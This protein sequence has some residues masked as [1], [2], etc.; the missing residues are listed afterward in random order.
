[1]A[2]LTNVFSLTYLHNKNTCLIEQPHREGD[3][4]KGEGV[5]CR[6]DD[7]G[8][9]EDG[10][11]DMAA[12]AAHYVSAEYAEFGEQPADYRNL[13]DYAHCEREHHQC[14]DVGFDGDGVLHHLAHLI[15]SEEAERERKDEEVGQQHSE[16]E[17]DITAEHDTDGTAPLILIKRRR[18]EMKEQIKQVRRSEDYSSTESHLDMDDELLSQ[19]CVDKADVQFFSCPIAHSTAIADEREEPCAKVV[20]Q[21]VG[22]EVCTLRSKDYSE[23]DVFKEKGDTTANDNSGNHFDKTAA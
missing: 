16:H 6:C 19:T 15:H 12:I 11:K 3:N 8:D 23:Q 5:G 20:E 17:H 2:V 14:V 10:N 13:E 18:N 7:G 9:D 1:M 22:D 21:T 4:E